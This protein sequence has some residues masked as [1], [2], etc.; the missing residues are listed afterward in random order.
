M[1]VQKH[2]RVD[3]QRGRTAKPKAEWQGYINWQPKET[4]KAELEA[5]KQ[6]NF[7]VDDLLEEAVLDGYKFSWSWDDYNSCFSASLYCTN[8]DSPNAGWCAVMRGDS[9]GKCLERVLFFHYIV[10]NRDWT[11]IA[12]PNPVGDRW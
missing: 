2:K 10:S 8:P 7:K 12:P 4:D 6:K 5:M 11:S 3:G 1:S 9:L